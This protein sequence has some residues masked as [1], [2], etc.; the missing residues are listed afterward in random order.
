MSY[1][2]EKMPNDPSLFSPPRYTLWVESAERYIYNSQTGTY[3]VIRSTP[4]LGQ[5]RHYDDLKKAKQRAG[6]MSTAY[7]NRGKFLVDWALYE[8]TGTEYK[9]IFDG[10]AGEDKANSELFKTRLTR[11]ALGDV[12]PKKGIDY[13]VEAA[14]QSI[15]KAAS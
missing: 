10:I 12:K 11:K 4:P 2:L 13:E 3:D 1:S 8:W 7:N 14:L 15:A 5:I 9:L 6:V